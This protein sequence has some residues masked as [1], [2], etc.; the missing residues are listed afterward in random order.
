M[1]ETVQLTRES[2]TTITAVDYESDATIKVTSGQAKVSLGCEGME[3]NPCYK[4]E[5]C[6]AA[7]TEGNKAV[8]Q[9][10]YTHARRRELQLRGREL[11]W[12]PPW[13]PNPPTV[14]IGA[15]LCSQSGNRDLVEE[16]VIDGRELDSFSGPL[17]RIYEKTGVKLQK[18]YMYGI[19]GIHCK[20]VWTA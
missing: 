11:L 17:E 10:T 2:S 14:C 20:L 8:I 18:D 13:C 7:I 12:C 16:E 1:A 3:S 4:D 5:A 15:G 6:D 19:D 9:Y